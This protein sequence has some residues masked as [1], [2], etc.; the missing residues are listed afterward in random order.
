ME[1]SKYV[2]ENEQKWKELEENKTKEFLDYLG[3][4]VYVKMDRPLGKMHPK[5]NYLYPINYGFVPHTISGDGKEIDAYIL[6][7][8]VTLEEYSGE[9]IAIVHRLDDNDDKLIVSDGTN[10]TDEEIEKSI[11]FQEKYFKH[12][13]I[14]NN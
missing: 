7:E 5:Y 6:G 9:V 2:E 11:E 13:I 8:D 3:K 14:R 10:Y 1:L 12:I 4:K